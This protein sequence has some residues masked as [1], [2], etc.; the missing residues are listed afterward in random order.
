MCKNWKIEL[1]NAGKESEYVTSTRYTIL[2]FKK[3]LNK[4]E[5]YGFG[6][7]R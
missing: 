3:R 2:F 5:Q 7:H 6:R 1:V 4:D